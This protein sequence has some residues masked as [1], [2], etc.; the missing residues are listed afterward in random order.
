MVCHKNARK[1]RVKL[2]VVGFVAFFPNKVLQSSGMCFLQCEA[3]H[4]Y[5]ETPLFFNSLK[6]L[7]FFKCAFED[8]IA[9]SR[10]G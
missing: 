7:L 9:V 5:N 8:S 6:C 1:R 3:V 2:S 4:C 10:L